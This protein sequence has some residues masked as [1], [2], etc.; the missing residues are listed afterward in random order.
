MSEQQ[1]Y[2][3]LKQYFGYDKFKKGQE[4]LIEHILKGQDVLGIMPTGAG[5]SI[6]YQ[7]P[8][9]M[10]DGV[11]IVISPLISL[12]KDQV[13]ALGE[14]GI[15]A[16]FINSSLST[17]EFRKVLSNARLGIYK[18]IYV[19][20]ERMETESFLQLIK[21]IKVSLIAVDEAHCVSQWGHDFRPSYVRIAD[22][23]DLLPQRPMVAAF[24]AT[25]TPQVKEDIIRLLK[26]S[27]PFVLITSFDRENL[28][29]GV[30]KPENKPK[31]LVDYL[32][33][34]INEDKSG[35]IY[36]STR[37]TVEMVSEKLDKKGFSVTKYHAGLPEKERTENQDDFLYDRK[38]IMVAT[39]AFGMGIDK[40]NIRFVIHY[41][42][43]KNMESYYQEAGRAGRDGVASEC[44]LLFSTADIVIN[45]FLIEK[46]SDSY[47]KTGDYQ[48]LNKMVDYCN[49]DNCLRKYILNYFGEMNFPSVCNNCSSCNNE[50][51]R[52]DITVEAQKILSCIKRMDERFG[53]GVVADV[54]KGAN[55]GKIRA[56]GF[57]KLSTYGIMRDYS[58]DTIKELISYLVAE[59][60]VEL[61]SGKYAVLRLNKIAYSV[62]KGQEPV[63]I[64]RV[65]EKHDS[66]NKK[67][68]TEVI[69]IELFGILR[70]LRGEIARSQNVP[71]FM[72]FSDATLNDIC[73]KYPTTDEDFLNISG[74]GKY[75]LEKYGEYFIPIIK[76]YV[77]EHGIEVDRSR[78][79]SYERN[80]NSLTDTTRQEKP[81]RS[82]KPTMLITYDLYTSG[83]SI[84][85]IMEIRGVTRRTIEGHL[86]ECLYKD[87]P[88]DYES[89]IPAELEPQIV[90]AIKENGLDKLKPI[91][92]ALPDEISYTM[93]RLVIYKLQSGVIKL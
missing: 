54:L 90:E 32:Q 93:I 84:E 40:S 89:L 74:I 56:N 87:L 33:M 80:Y 13:D 14:M 76:N 18:L 9:L 86:I 41:N 53:G 57:D 28:Y 36:C 52:T 7:I 64:K 23:V 58:K 2:S 48:K 30:T 65:I 75:K 70:T 59:N 51:E 62:L 39:N 3:V 85:K 34:S 10:S 27:T 29:F 83:N 5:K 43:P 82:E 79:K 45:K 88:L 17:R 16:A 71:P 44:I 35:L 37:K 49:T 1:I 11:T 92:E 15:K 6:C 60:Y 46:S 68:S 22:M 77:E 12:M 31:F 47:D 66:Q 73:K 38:Q 24:T 63:S 91:K 69:D 61:T 25:A 55:T 81:E 67:R 26:L 50:I 78:A 42:M 19:A 4:E 72:V 8:A 21:T 20:P